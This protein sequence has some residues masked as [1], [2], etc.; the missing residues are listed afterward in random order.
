MKR[1]WRSSG[2]G[3]LSGHGHVDLQGMCLDCGV[4]RRFCGFEES[5]KAFHLKALL[6][7]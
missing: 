5:P 6:L 2:E 3:R 1:I 7:G 4:Y